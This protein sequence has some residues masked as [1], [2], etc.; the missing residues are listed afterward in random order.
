MQGHGDLKRSAS[1]LFRTCLVALFHCDATACRPGGR[2]HFLVWGVSV[3]PSA[4]LLISDAE[5][6]RGGEGCLHIKSA[7]FWSRHAAPRNQH[8]R[9]RGSAR[10]LCEM[11][12]RLGGSAAASRAPNLAEHSSTIAFLE[13]RQEVPAISTISTISI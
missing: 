10:R 5:R 4:R 12:L 9:N 1:G 6:V 2:E 8:L 13:G 3:R 7:F 11:D